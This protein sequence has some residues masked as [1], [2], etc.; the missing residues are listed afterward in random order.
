MSHIIPVTNTIH[1]PSSRTEKK[2]QS[3]GAPSDR[4]YFPAITSFHSS[5]VPME[6]NISISAHAQLVEC[7][8][9]HKS[10]R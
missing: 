7:T 10:K 8:E 3:L 2:K 6:K 4:A 1:I 9:I 5:E